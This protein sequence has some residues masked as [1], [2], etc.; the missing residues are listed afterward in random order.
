[1]VSR[2]MNTL[3]RFNRLRCIFL[4][5][6]GAA[7][8]AWADA[9]TAASLWGAIETEAVQPTPPA[10]WQQQAPSQ[11]AVQEWIGKERARLM[12]LADRARD[13]H[14]QFPQ[15]AHAETA[16]KK[17][18][19]A[20]SSVLQ[21][22]RDPEIEKRIAALEEMLL[23][24]T[25][26]SP[27]DRFGLRAAQVRRS[28][29]SRAE[30][31][32]GVRQLIQEFPG[33]PRA[34]QMLLAAAKGGDA[35]YARAIADEILKSPAP[36]DIKQRAKKMLEMLEIVGKPL[37]LKYTAL[38]G[39]QVDLQAMK[40]KVVLVDFWAT[41]CGPCVGELPNVKAA[42]SKLHDKGFEILG[43]SFDHDKA[44]L[45][46]FLKE[47]EMPWP[48]YFDGKGWSNSIGQQF[49][50]DAIPRMWLVDKNGVLRDQEGRGEALV[51]KIEKLLAE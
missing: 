11:A 23:R 42:Y 4:V 25:T 37:D 32:Q 35:A 5:F 15:D 40:G 49:G 41:W 36:D 51:E 26:L 39:R 44:A 34:Y 2:N 48:Q 28:A 45:E 27:Q 29:T 31:E 20:L 14:T 13:F 43:I 17:E 47:K 50:I 3:Q 19:Q 30:F 7:S 21:T 12:A 8:M 22:G 46:R 16:R 1:M 38:D 18:W 24:G 9:Q 10:A 33:E 6:L